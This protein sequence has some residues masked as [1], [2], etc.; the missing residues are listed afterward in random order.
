MKGLLGERLFHF[1]DTKKNG[2]LDFECFVQGMLSYCRGN[3][4]KK[5]R[6]IF[7]IC[8]FKEDLVIDGHE[9]LV[10]VKFI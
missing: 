7:E 10:S 3:I 1:F 5:Q 2:L 6:I 9:L 8:D 4:E